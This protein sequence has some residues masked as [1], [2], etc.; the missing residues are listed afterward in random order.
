MIRVALVGIGNCASALVQGVTY[1]RRQPD[2]PGI[3]TP[4]IHGLRISDIEFVAAFDIDSTKVGLPLREAIFAG[5]NNT[6]R[7]A[8]EIESADCLVEPAPA[9][10]GFGPK[11]TAKTS[12]STAPTE[13]M[14]AILK[15]ARPDVLVNYLPVGADIASK[16]WAETCIR[17]KIAFVN[18]IP[19]FVASDPD[20]ERRFR[21]AGVPIA[22]DDVKSQ[23][24]ATLLHRSLVRMFA[25]RGGQIDS[26]F[27]LNFG[28]NTDFENM[29]ED[30]RLDSK[31]KSKLSSV[32]SEF[33]SSTTDMHISPSGYISHL[34]DQKLAYVNVVG[35]A[36]GGAPIEIECR[37]KVWDSP[38]SAGVIA[39]V[40]RFAFSSLQR[41]EGGAIP[42]CDFY[43]K[44]PPSQSRDEDAWGAVTSS[45][46]RPLS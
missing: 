24:G 20:F 28:G 33:D 11:L 6:L 15:R 3:I 41:G 46:A 25:M 30:R 29:L 35:H 17:N 32:R 36:F 1:Y 40:I 45:A 21:E 16:Y 38:N 42:V 27:Q 9:L 12:L 7:F 43:F 26:T 34:Q 5:R 10:D 8:H 18:A 13:D 39:D 2:M 37:I 14:D 23:I 4:I 22:G 44:S 19:S 31:L